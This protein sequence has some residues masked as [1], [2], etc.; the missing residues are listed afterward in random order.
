M[1]SPIRYGVVGTGMMGVEHIANILALDGASVTAA[2]DPHPPSQKAARVAASD[3][4]LPVFESHIDLI[5][6]GLCDAVVVATPNM[7]HVGVLLDLMETDLHVLVEKPLCTTVADCR[8]VCE[9]DAQRDAITWVGLEYRYMPAIARLITEVKQGTVGDLKMVSIREHRFPFLDKVGDWN[10][11][12]QNTGGTLVEKCCHYFDLMNHITDSEPVRIYASGG[13]DVNHLDE[14]YDGRRPDILDNA[15]VVVDYRNGVRAMLDL[16]MF[17]E[18]GRNQEEVVVVGDLG[19]LEAH[20]PSGEIAIGGR[21]ENRF[22]PLV[23]KV[24]DRRIAYTG[25][26][27]GASYIEHM[28]F[29]AAVRSGSRPLVTLEDGLLAVAMGVAA[30]RSIEQHRAIE[31]HEILGPQRD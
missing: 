21:G 6:S 12:N 9:A 13:Q 19:K 11:F 31:M 28:H 25:I 29:L 26:H 17:A 5:E 18:G 23:E 14:T 16:C 30:H 8:R 4:S 10:R 2:A 3:K 15:Y 22:T 24:V 27:H 1:S 20:N 7:T